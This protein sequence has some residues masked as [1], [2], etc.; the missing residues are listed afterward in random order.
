M[1][2]VHL[3]CVT[4]NIL[5][6]LCNA[7]RI[8]EGGECIPDDDDDDDDYDDDD[9]N[10]DDDDD[11]DDDDYDDDDYDEEETDFEDFLASFYRRRVC[12][13]KAIPY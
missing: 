10:D 2:V 4:M 3:L 1:F 12:I 7:V 13:H 5:M 8:P 9:D 11:Y 6:C